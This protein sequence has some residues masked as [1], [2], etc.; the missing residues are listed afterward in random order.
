MPKNINVLSSAFGWFSQASNDQLARLSWGG[1]FLFPGFCPNR[2]PGAPMLI[3]GNHDRPPRRKSKSVY[4]YS[5]EG[6]TSKKSPALSAPMTT[7]PYVMPEDALRNAVITSTTRQ[8]KN[9]AQHKEPCN[10]MFCRSIGSGFVKSYLGKDESYTQRLNA[11]IYNL[12]LNQQSVGYFELSGHENSL[13]LKELIEYPQ[14]RTANPMI[15]LN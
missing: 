7:G 5:I 4:I 11:A 6:M 14:I 3:G 9:G 2:E 13:E 10:K 8:D 1:L 15:V 12:C